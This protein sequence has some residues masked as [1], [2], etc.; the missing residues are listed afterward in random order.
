M[1][2]AFSLLRPSSH[3]AADSFVCGLRAL[4]YTMTLSTDD[5]GPGDVFLTWNRHGSA[6]DYA[7]E[8]ARRGATVIV[9][10]NG[11]FG[12]DWRGDTWF[13]LALDHHNG[14][15]RWPL[16]EGQRWR[17]IGF[18]LEP[19]RKGGVEIVILPQRG[20]GEPGVAMPAG[21]AER[22]QIDI[23]GRIRPHP[24][25]NAEDSLRADLANAS[26]VVTWGSGA[27]IKAIAWGIGCVY[28][29]DDWIGQD[30]GTHIDEYL[31]IE[32]NAYIA[33]G[34]YDRDVMFESLACAMWR[35]G[36]VESGEAFERLLALEEAK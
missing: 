16:D 2:R 19:W 9:A 33:R 35:V 6:N 14:A 36:E 22:V 7:N 30:A 17:A 1:K 24:G 10:E 26:A 11:Y 4:G 31:D 15:G 8:A 27:A 3:Y 34:D 12:R 28:A 25:R 29:F 13:A 5:L 21:W 23:E 18:E 32:R 20:I